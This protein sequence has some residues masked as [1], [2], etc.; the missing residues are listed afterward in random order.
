MFSENYLEFPTTF[1]FYS[2]IKYLFYIDC[3]IT[4]LIMNSEFFQKQYGLWQVWKQYHFNIYAIYRTLPYVYSKLFEKCFVS[5]WRMA[6]YKAEH[7]YCIIGINYVRLHYNN[8]LYIYIEYIT[9]NRLDLL[10]Y[11]MPFNFNSFWG[12]S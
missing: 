4:P 7:I 6:V 2:T 3:Q 1:Y 12:F 8:K 5:L 11:I 10:I 9:P